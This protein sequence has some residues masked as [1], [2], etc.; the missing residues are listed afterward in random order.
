M[1]VK[2]SKEVKVGVLA[3][4]ALTIVYIGFNFLKGK[5]FLS[6]NHSYRAVYENCSGLSTASPV[7]LNG[8]PVGRVSLR[9]IPLISTICMTTLTASAR[10]ATP[11]STLA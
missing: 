4:A 5:N 2:M 3:T 7:F 6:F 1:K 11:P 8:V 9:S 10:A